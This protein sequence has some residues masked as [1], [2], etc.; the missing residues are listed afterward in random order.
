MSQSGVSVAPECI[1]AF[2][3]LKLGKASKYII[4]KL[5][6]D[7]KEIVIE[8]KGTDDNYDVFQQKLIDAKTMSKPGKPGNQGKEGPGP[9]YAV[10]DVEYDL[11]NGEGKRNKIALITWVPED[12]PQIPRMTYP[13]S[14]ESLKRALNGVAEDIQANDVGQLAYSEILNKV[15]RGAF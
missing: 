7:Y 11:P 4:F 15:S 2:N 10:Y 1:T 9:R 12:A 13:S 3:E 14:K 5:S 8:E 6:D